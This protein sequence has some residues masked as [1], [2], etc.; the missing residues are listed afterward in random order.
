[1]LRSVCA[2]QLLALDADGTDHDTDLVM[3]DKS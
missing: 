3:I 2:I 1:M